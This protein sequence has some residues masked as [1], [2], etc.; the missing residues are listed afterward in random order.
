M[1]A[2]HMAQIAAADAA[3]AVIVRSSVAYTKLYIVCPLACCSA[4]AASASICIMQHAMDNL[5]Q[6]SLVGPQQHLQLV[7]SI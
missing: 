5:M 1:H 3:A 6:C 4:H 7:A 2:V